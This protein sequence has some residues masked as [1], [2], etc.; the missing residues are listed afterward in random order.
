MAKRIDVESETNDALA[1]WTLRD[2]Q[3]LRDRARI[4]LIK[5]EVTTDEIKWYTNEPKVFYETAT[6]LLSSFPP[7]FRMPLTIDYTPEQKDKMSKAE[8]FII[9]VFRSF[10]ERQI[11]NFWLRDLAYRTLGGWYSVFTLARRRFDS[12]EFIADIWDPISVYPKWDDYGLMRCIRS[13]EVDVPTARAMASGWQKVGL[14][15]NAKMP[16]DEQSRVRVINYWRREV[17]IVK[18]KEVSRVFNSILLNGEIVKPMKHEKRFNKIPILVGAIGVPDYTVGDWPARYG[19]NIIAANRDM[20]DYENDMASLMS[21]ILHEMAYPNIISKTQSG[22]PV[23]KKAMRGYGEEVPLRRGE[24]LEVLRTASTPAEVD[25]LMGWANRNKQKGAFS[26]AV[27]GGIPNFEISGFAL[28]QFLASVRYKIGPYLFIL[29]RLCGRVA[30]ELQEQY[31]KGDGKPFPKVSL[32]TNNPNEI[33]KGLFFVEEFSP[34]DVPDSSFVECTIPITSATD[35]IQQMLYARQALQPPQ[36]LSRETLWDEM[37]DV[38][39]S[40]QEY[41]RIIQDEILEDPIVRRIASIEQLRK[42]MDAERVKGNMPAANALNRYIMMLELQLGM[43]Q[44]IPESGVSPNLSP[45]EFGAAG[46][47]SPDVLGAITGQPPPSPNRT[48][49]EGIVSPGGERLL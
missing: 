21:L 9:G 18:G 28:S 19:E 44:G 46:Q 24:T 34:K 30:T 16:A 10:D 6:A 40:E 7:R 14:D 37:L 20:Y 32:T 5:K 36:L 23:T 8:R 47:P 42:R 48:R 25:V 43:R 31:K 27:Y 22:S 3:M 13:Y 39:D 41:A 33:R 15:F 4:N 26:D 35:K 29:Q 38:Q 17:D 1:Y 11:Q 49:A 45:P 12:V 2:D